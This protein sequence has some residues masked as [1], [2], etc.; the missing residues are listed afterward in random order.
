MR[1]KNAATVAIDLNAFRI[2]YNY[3]NIKLATCYYSLFVIP[4]S[5]C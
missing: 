2:L 3:L 1:M 4:F 5:H